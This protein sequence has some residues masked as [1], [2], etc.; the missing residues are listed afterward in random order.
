MGLQQYPPIGFDQGI[1]AV[2][3]MPTLPASHP[4]QAFNLLS[5]IKKLLFCHD[6]LTT[7][8]VH[9]DAPPLPQG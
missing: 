4:Y 7:W 8:T 6:V 5:Y 2:A 3:A 9:D 1:D